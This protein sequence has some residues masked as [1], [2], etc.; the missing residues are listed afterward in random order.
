MMLSN[1]RHRSDLSAYD[2]VSAGLL[3]GSDTMR[4]LAACSPRTFVIA[5]VADLAAMAAAC[6]PHSA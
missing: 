2:K 5:A 1:S 3:D 6:R 4:N